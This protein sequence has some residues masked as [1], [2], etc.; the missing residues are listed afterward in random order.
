[1]SVVKKIVLAQLSALCLAQ[2][3]AIATERIKP[4]Q[5][6]AAERVFD[7]SW[8]RKAGDGSDKSR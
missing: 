7:F 6:V 8:A 3:I 1:M 5:A 2:M 4:K